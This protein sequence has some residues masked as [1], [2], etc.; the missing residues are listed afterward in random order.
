[1]SIKWIVPVI[2]ALVGLD[3]LTKWWAVTA[4][5]DGTVIPVWPSVFELRYTENRGAA[6]GMLQNQ[7]W[8]FIVMTL[9]LIVVIGYLL[10]SKKLPQHPLVWTAC[11][12]IVA[13]GIGNLIDRIARE[14]VV[15]FLYFRLINFP[16]FNVADIFVTVGA[17]AGIVYLLFF[18]SQKPTE[19]FDGSK[20]ALL[21]SGND[22]A[23]AGQGAG[24]STGSDA[25]DGAE[26]DGAGAGDGRRHTAD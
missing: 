16:I 5:A 14:F 10:F 25:V 18:D 3:Q 11:L 1:M 7:Q 4:L 15:D 21:D 19:E 2:A 13:G 23:T 26:M 17:A 9:L 6:F 8:L 12:L 20:D 24:G 22:G